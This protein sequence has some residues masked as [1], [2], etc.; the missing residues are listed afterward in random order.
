MDI[1]YI[2]TWWQFA[3]LIF[4]FFSFFY[5]NISHYKVAFV[6]I[7]YKNVMLKIAQWHDVIA[8]NLTTCLRCVIW[9]D[10]LVYLPL[11]T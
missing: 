10:V 9:K 7:C 4:T 1:F 11:L 3:T 8:E 5:R 2:P 6:T